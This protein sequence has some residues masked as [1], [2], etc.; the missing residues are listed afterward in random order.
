V[1]LGPSQQKDPTFALKGAERAREIVDMRI[2]GATFEIIS[3]T[4]KIS[5]PRAHKIYQDYLRKILRSAIE[6]H[7]KFELE[8]IADLRARLWAEK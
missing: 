1:R 5:R 4:L 6:Q 3:K 7:R 8:R 2:R